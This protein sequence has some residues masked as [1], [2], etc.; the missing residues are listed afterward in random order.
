MFK[1]IISLYDY[2]GHFSAPW[3]AAGYQVIC[4]DKQID[5]QDARKIRYQ[6]GLNVEGV[7]GAPPCI[8]FSKAN[9]L[10]NFNTNL[11][12]AL[13]TV[14]AFMRYVVLYSPKWYV[15]ENPSESRVWRYIGEPKQKI[16][17]YDF[18]YPALKGTG[19]WG[20]FNK[21]KKAAHSQVTPIK[22]QNLP[23]SLRSVTPVQLGEAFFKANS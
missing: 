23:K 3:K 5:N 12:E 22:F 19:L 14:D 8:F 7:I 15:L 18:G 6:P 20:K 16:K 4:I 13:S 9:S 2:T 17:L 21:V 11:I 1:T 10:E